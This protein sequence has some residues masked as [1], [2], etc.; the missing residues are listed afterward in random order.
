MSTIPPAPATPE[1]DP[2]LSREK[3][4]ELL[5]WDFVT[6]IWD[7]KRSIFDLCRWIV[8]LQALVVGFVALREVEFE[9]YFFAVPLLI[10]GVGLY[11]LSGFQQEL[12]SHRRTVAEIRHRVGGDFRDITIDHFNVFREGKKGR[13]TYWYS[14]ATGHWI[15]IVVST[16]VSVAAVLLAAS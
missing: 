15:I 9:I 1:T 12:F 10:G 5:Y 4:F 14:I 7:R 11:L 13:D 3:Q 6:A 16:A 2:P 8:T